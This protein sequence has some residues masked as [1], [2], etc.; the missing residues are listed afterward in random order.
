MGKQ[1]E[2]VGFSL[3]LHSDVGLVPV[4]SL[5]RIHPP[6]MQSYSVQ[7]ICAFGQAK[8]RKPRLWG[9]VHAA[10][11]RSCLSPPPVLVADAEVQH[12]LQLV[13]GAV[14]LVGD[15]TVD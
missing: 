7:E 1:K 13:L 3:L 15:D 12:V 4:D 11:G 5:G 10:F 2:V 6:L 9:P 8:P 14:D